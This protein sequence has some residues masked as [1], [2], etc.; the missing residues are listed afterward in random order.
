MPSGLCCVWCR[1]R[2]EVCSVL[3][4][5][6]ASRFSKT[7]TLSVLLMVSSMLDCTFPA[8]INQMRRFR[9]SN[10]MLSTCKHVIVI[11]VLDRCSGSLF[12]SD[13]RQDSPIS[14][15]TVAIQDASIRYDYRAAAPSLSLHGQAPRV[16][17]CCSHS[18]SQPARAPLR[19]CRPYRAYVL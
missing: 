1:G 5:A 8:A 18:F 17:R 11:A 16:I 4:S 7:S 6:T 10:H 13:R 3:S 9:I 14:S 12:C 2:D 19:S 15:T